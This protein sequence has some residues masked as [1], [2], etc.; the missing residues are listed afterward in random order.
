MK[1]ETNRP[2]AVLIMAAGKGTRMNSD[3]PKVLHPVGGLPMI[4]RVIRLSRTLHADP[5]VA[6]IGHKFELVEAALKDEKVKFAYQLEQK[7]TGHAVEQCREIMSGFDGDVLVLSGDVPLLTAE[8]LYS[9]LE[10]HKTKKAVCTVLTADFEDPTGYGR[11]IRKADNTLNN[12]VEH[13]DASAEEL[14]VPEINTGI[15]VFDSKTLFD[16]LPLIGNNN[17]QGE[18]YLPDVLPLI[19]ANNQRIAVEKTKNITEIQGVN[20]VQQLELINEVF[21]N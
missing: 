18:Y 17:S 2:L 14:A 11:V 8:T 7:G 1:F 19:L 5:I 15:Y 20:T 16:K 6:I 3:L 4:T 10:V 21:Q 9:L 13:K 12:I